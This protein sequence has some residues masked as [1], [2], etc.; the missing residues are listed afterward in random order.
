MSLL[1]RQ[2]IESRTRLRQTRT[3]QENRDML[4]CGISAINA[5]H[6]QREASK[7]QA[8]TSLTESS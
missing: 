4:L 8:N 3:G 7:A 2:M 1:V 6:L 5:A